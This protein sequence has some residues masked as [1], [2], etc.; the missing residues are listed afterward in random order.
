MVR[1]CIDSKFINVIK[2]RRGEIKGSRSRGCKKDTKLSML[3]DKRSSRLDHV[4]EG[5]EFEW[6]C[7]VRFVILAWWFILRYVR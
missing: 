4:H 2:V 3:K 7:S 1:L 6:L 5:L